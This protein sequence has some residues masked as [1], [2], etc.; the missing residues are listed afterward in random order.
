MSGGAGSPLEDL[1]DLEEV[2]HCFFR[3]RPRG[4]P[5]L[6]PGSEV[7]PDAWSLVALSLLSSEGPSSENWAILR[8]SMSCT[9]LSSSRIFSMVS[10]YH[11]SCQ[12]Q[13]CRWA[14]T[15]TRRRP[16]S[17]MNLSILD[18][19]PQYRNSTLQSL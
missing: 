10:P 14:L 7:V 15:I 1:E 6:L 5:F 12:H 4:S 3:P 2:D 16:V 9:S 13:A 19:M 17:W 8:D 18:C 11:S